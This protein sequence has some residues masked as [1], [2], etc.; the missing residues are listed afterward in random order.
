M[1]LQIVF[2]KLHVLLPTAQLELVESKPDGLIKF[3]GQAIVD[4]A[5]MLRDRLGFE[6][7]S[8]ISGC[9][10]PAISALSVTY[11]FASYQHRFIVALRAYLSKSVE[12]PEVPSLCSL[13]KAANWLERETFDM[14]GIRFRDHP[15]MR[16]ILLP[17][18]WTGYPLRKDYQT[19]DYYNGMPVPLAFDV[20]GTP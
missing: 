19:P 12:N 15:D 3:D 5:L 11:H 13:F 2:E 8:C 18:D 20:E 7:L 6:T 1:N 14:V 10:H 9:D 16:R 17:E 4:V